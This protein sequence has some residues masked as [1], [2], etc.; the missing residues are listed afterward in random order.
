MC[1]QCHSQ[2]DDKLILS[3]LQKEIKN[4][5]YPGYN[6]TSISHFYLAAMG[7]NGLEARDTALFV[8]DNFIQ[9]YRWNK[10]DHYLS[11]TMD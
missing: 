6:S 1:L 9:W 8:L 5:N 4:P 7:L 10:Q 11:R 3:Q 2:I